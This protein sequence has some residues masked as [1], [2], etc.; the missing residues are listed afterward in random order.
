MLSTGSY[1]T[2]IINNINGKLIAINPF[3]P[4]GLFV[5]I[6]LEKFISYIG[7]GGGGLWLVFI[8]TMFYRNL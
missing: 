2:C 3:M 6:S 5:L 7:W 8:I 4:S 1:Y